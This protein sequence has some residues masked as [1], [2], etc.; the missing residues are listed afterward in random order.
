MAPR[1]S[2]SPGS[3]RSREPVAAPRP[4]TPPEAVDP[5]PTTAYVVERDDRFDFRSAEYLDLFDRSG[6]TLFQ[7]PGWLHHVYATLA[8][9]LGARPLVVTV[10]AAGSGRLLAVLP[11]VR[12]R[13]R[14]LR[15]VELAD[16][17]VCDHAAPVV[18]RNAAP[19]LRAV[20]GLPDAIWTALGR[21]DLLRVER[22][23]GAPDA[24]A[25]L[26]G[27]RTHRRLP[28]DTH[29][30]SLPASLEEWHATLAPSFVRHLRRKRD[31]LRPKGGVGFRTVTD[32]DEVD[33]L[34]D[35][36]RAFRQA[37]FSG[38][39]AVDLVQ[40]PRRFAFYRSVARDGVAAGG[41]AVL[42]VLSVGDRPAAVSL[43]LADAERHLFLV[44][45]Y[46][47]GRL[48][49]YS[50]GL[51]IVDE[52]AQAAIARGVRELDLTVGNEGYKADFGATPTPLWSTRRARTLRGS[53]GGVLIDVE[54]W[55]RRRTKAVLARR[56]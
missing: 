50:L 51:L 3:S 20:P 29:A 37:R 9:Q 56:R 8:P 16:L 30:V 35:D 31:R 7:H 54:A 2:R 49:N 5:V 17:G 55:A 11:L 36:L 1:S 42:S 12:R 33:P 52:L 43:D 41:P 15:L 18:D 10:R 13:W 46:D 6:A 38:R 28:Y 34:L 40:D 47:F 39:R 45:G 19:W 4:R 26:L 32:P 27:T 25:D 23:P 21:F 53:A 48:R 14:G 44:V 22:I 24:F